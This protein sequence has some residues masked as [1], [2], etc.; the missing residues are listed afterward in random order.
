MSDSEAV[1]ALPDPALLLERMDQGFYFVGNDWR[2]RLVNRQAA[3]FWGR[4]RESLV[5]RS[6]FELFPRFEGSPSHRAHVL[7]METGQ[8]ATLETVSTA[9]GLPVILHLH[10]EHGGLSVLFRDIHDRREMEQELRERDELLTLAEES[11]GIG[12]WVQDVPKQTMRAT[13]QFYRLLGIDPIAGPVSLDFI[14]SFRHPGDRERLLREFEKALAAGAETFEAEYRITRASGEERWILGRGRV[15][16]DAE[17]RPQRYSGV[18]LDITDRRRAEE[19]L[20]VVMG[21]LVHRTKNLLT[22][23]QSLALQTAHRTDTVPAFLEMFGS[24]LGA[25]SRSTDLLVRADW[26]GVLLEELIATQTAPFAERGRLDISGVAVRLSAKAA[27]NLGLAF[28]ELATNA[29]KYGALSSPGGRVS[30]R[31][32]V[33]QGFLRLTWEE[34]GGPTVTAPTRKGYGRVVAEDIVRGA[35]GAEV[36]TVFR[37]EG[38]LWK[39]AVPPSELVG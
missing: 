35:L 11:A 10:P 3:V 25:L 5:G 30:I 9:T 29:L 6:M 37:R 17:G 39:V 28:H 19:H 1:S 14:R 31:W 21:E 33:E 7:A 15:T 34:T 20:H 8:P 26:K 22:V 36:S 24:R 18:D 13:P 16:R 38:L 27:Q 4:P 2:L 32:R 12:V 23:V